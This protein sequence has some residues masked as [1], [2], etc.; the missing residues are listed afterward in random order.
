MVKIINAFVCDSTMHVPRFSLRLPVIFCNIALRNYFFLC[1][2]GIF[3]FIF[4]QISYDGLVFTCFA[5]LEHVMRWWLV[6]LVVSI[7]LSSVFPG[8]LTIFACYGTIC[9]HF[10][11]VAF[12]S[13]HLHIHSLRLLVLKLF[14]LWHPSIIRWLFLLSAIFHMPFSLFIFCWLCSWCSEKFYAL[15]YSHIFSQSHIHIHV[16][17]TQ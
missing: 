11:L 4:D 7:S 6:F 16:S 10:E 2:V 9:I 5:W 12:F 15:C 8:I 13:Y 1:F 14:L 3:F 17:Y